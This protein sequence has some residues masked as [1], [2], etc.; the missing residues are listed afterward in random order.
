MGAAFP[1]FNPASLRAPFN[2][3]KYLPDARPAK[4]GE[5]RHKIFLYVFYKG[6]LAK[7]AI[8]WGIDKR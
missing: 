1:P 6:F 2:L 5:F 4:N 8:Y 3:R 7:G